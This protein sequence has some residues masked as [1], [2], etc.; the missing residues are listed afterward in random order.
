MT[1]AKSPLVNPV[2]LVLGCTLF[3]AAAQVLL[4]LGAGN[5]MPALDFSSPSSIAGFVSA[6][7]Q[8]WRLA[9]GYALH[10]CNAV[11]LILALREGQLSVLYPIYALSYIWVDLLSLY[12]FNEHMNVWKAAGIFLIIAGVSQLGRVSAKS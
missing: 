5:P 2:F 7:L 4:K 9:F 3:A 12:F 6:L 1:P 8:N 11:L 10:G